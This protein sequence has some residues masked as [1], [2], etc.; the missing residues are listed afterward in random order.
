MVARIRW[1]ESMH[2]LGKNLPNKE[3]TTLVNNS[4]VKGSRM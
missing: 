3:K 2:K 1:H 4:G